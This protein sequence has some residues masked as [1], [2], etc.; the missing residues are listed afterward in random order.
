MITAKLVDT[1]LYERFFSVCQS[2]RWSARWSFNNRKTSLAWVC[3]GK[4]GEAVY[5]T[6]LH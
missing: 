6:F 2:I 1:Q 4:G 3:V 5:D